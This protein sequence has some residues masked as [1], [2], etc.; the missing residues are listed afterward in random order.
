M[1]YTL[2]IVLARKWCPEEFSGTLSLSFKKSGRH[3]EM[4]MLQV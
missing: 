2:E 4:L 3:Y 1:L